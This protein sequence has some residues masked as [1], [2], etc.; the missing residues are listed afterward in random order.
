M[1]KLPAVDAQLDPSA[2]FFDE[3]LLQLQRRMRKEQFDRWFRGFSLVRMGME[4]VEFSV[5][6]GFVR[7]WLTRNYLSAIQESVYAAV[8]APRRVSLSLREQSNSEHTLSATEHVGNLMD[9]VSGQFRRAESG[10][11]STKSTWA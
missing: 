11:A 4:D 3:V 5:P 8:E 10:S 1:V 7:D 2:S 9:E 6:S